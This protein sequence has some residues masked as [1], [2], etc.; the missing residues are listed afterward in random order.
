M[1]LT[2]AL[3]T[4]WRDAYAHLPGFYEVLRAW[5]ERCEW[6]MS[7]SRAPLAE[8]A[9][10]NDWK[11]ASWYAKSGEEPVWTQLEAIRLDAPPTYALSTEHGPR[12]LREALDL[13]EQH[14]G[15]NGV[16]E[17]LTGFD[18]VPLAPYTGCTA[19]HPLEYAGGTRMLYAAEWPIWSWTLRTP[20]SREYLL[21]ELASGTLEDARYAD[22]Y[23]AALVVLCC[24]VLR[25]R[26][27]ISFTW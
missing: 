20:G 7:T 18:I 13:L 23:E 17:T 16:L 11:T 5:F 22:V 19:V 2:L 26:V 3:S 27:P 6:Q 24:H 10:A 14:A 15:G 4:T 8:L 25:E 1:G 12:A 21:G 9:T